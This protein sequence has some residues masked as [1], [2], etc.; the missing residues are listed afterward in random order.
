MKRGKNN[1][2][3]ENQN[4]DSWAELPEDW[5]PDLLPDWEIDTLAW[6]DIDLSTWEME[7]PEWDFQPFEWDFQLL[8]GWEDFPDSNDIKEWAE[9]PGIKGK[10]EKRGHS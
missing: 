8:E 6:E 9:S 3:G 7:L 10:G 4:P 2:K 5:I 1:Q